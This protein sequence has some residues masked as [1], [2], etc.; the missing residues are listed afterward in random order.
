MHFFRSL[1]EKDLNSNGFSIQNSQS[2]P[3]MYLVIQRDSVTKYL[4]YKGDL[5][6]NYFQ[7]SNG[8]VISVMNDTVCF[9][10]QGYFDPLG[11][12]WTSEM[13]RQ[14]IADLLPYEYSMKKTFR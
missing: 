4:K 7:K 10:K 5:V 12:S 8:S 1:W 11:I 9:N 2:L 3:A 6:I 13:A 14:R